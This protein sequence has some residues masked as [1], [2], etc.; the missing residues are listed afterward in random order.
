MR[1]DNGRSRWFSDSLFDLDGGAVPL[2]TAWR[3]DNPVVDELNGRDETNNWVDI[4]LKFDNG[5]ERWCQMATPDYLKRTLDNNPEEPMFYA[6]NLIIVR[7]LAT[8][9][10]EQVLGYMDRQ[11][12]LIT[13]SLSLEAPEEPQEEEGDPERE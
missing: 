1:A 5:T 4:R 3:F 7:D 9:T 13:F 6:R 8:E 10:V 2:L 12:E 11:D